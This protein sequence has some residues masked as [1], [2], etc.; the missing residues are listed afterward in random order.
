MPISHEKI[1]MKN[2]CDLIKICIPLSKLPQA[3]AQTGR[4]LISEVTLQRT[5]IC[6]GHRYIT[7]LH[8]NQFLVC[9]KVVIFRQDTSTDQFFLQNLYEVQQ[10][11]R[12]LITNVINCIRRNR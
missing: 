12:V 5:G 6:I 7:R 1:Q 2:A 3:L 11:F 4:G 10:I 9:F 8:R